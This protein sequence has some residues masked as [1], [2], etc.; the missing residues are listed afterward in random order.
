MHFGCYFF[1][2]II[3]KSGNISIVMEKEIKKPGVKWA[4]ML[5]IEVAN[6]SGWESYNDYNTLYVT[7]DEF[8]NRASNSVLVTNRPIS[9]RDANKTKQKL[10]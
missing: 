2:D 5:N 6:P 1:V 4:K 10:N 7:K 9:R 3:Y 8:C